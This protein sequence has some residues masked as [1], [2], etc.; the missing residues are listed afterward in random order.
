M[1]LFCKETACTLSVIVHLLCVYVRV[2]LSALDCVVHLPE[3]PGAFL[4]TKKG[5]GGNGAVAT[6]DHDTDPR[7][8]EGH[9]EVNDL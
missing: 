5:G 6:R 9:R 8:D 1:S 3:A 2:H 7:L 4:L